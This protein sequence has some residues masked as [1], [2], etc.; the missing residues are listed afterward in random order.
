MTGTPHPT[1]QRAYSRLTFGAYVG[2]D[3]VKNWGVSTPIE[4]REERGIRGL[5]PPGYIPLELDVQRCMEHLRAKESNLDKYTYLASI[6][7]VSERLYF[8]ILAS[9]TAEVMPI[10]YTPIVGEACENFSRIYRGTLR[11]MYFSLNDAGKIRSILNNW[12]TDKVTTIVM[13]DGER[14]LGLGDLGVNGMGIPI[15]KL[16]LYTVRLKEAMHGLALISIDLVVSLELTFLLFEN[17]TCRLAVAFTQLT[18]SLF[19]WMWA[20]TTRNFYWTSTI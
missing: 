10:V 19:N 7:D 8:A 11:G 16:A 6:Q 17:K 3:P 13:T 9:H 20:P 14:I 15:G 1:R 12:P 2:R 18:S 5:V 4:N